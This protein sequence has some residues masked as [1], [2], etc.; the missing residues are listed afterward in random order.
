MLVN[1]EEKSINM[2]LKNKQPENCN[3]NETRF[4]PRQGIYSQTHNHTQSEELL[5]QQRL[6]LQSNPTNA[7]PLKATLC[8]V[9]YV[10]YS[11]I[12]WQINHF[13]NS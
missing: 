1:Y 11:N 9:Q 2:Y 5:T 12:N 13:C 8:I 4:L 6:H 7:S 3:L 10:A